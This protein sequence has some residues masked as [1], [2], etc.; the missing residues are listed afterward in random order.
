MRT[1]EIYLTFDILAKNAS[2]TMKIWPKLTKIDPKNTEKRPIS[3]MKF[4]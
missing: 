1:L 2:I 3:E 4:I